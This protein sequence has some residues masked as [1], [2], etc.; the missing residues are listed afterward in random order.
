MNLKPSTA[1]STQRTHKARLVAVRGSG[2]PTVTRPS[3]TGNYVAS[4][5]KTNPGVLHQPQALKA[6]AVDKSQERRETGEGSPTGDTLTG[7]MVEVSEAARLSLPVSQDTETGAVM[8]PFVLGKGKRPLMPAHPARVRQLLRKRKA[9]VSRRFPFVIRLKTRKDGEVQPI[10]VKLDP[11]AK[12]TGIALVRLT[13]SNPQIQTVLGRIE[14]THR[15]TQIRDALTQ[16]RSFRGARCGRKTRYRAPRFLNRTKPQGW[17]PP[18]LRHRLE[19]TMSW[20][21]RLMLNTPE[22]SAIAGVDVNDTGMG[23]KDIRRAIDDFMAR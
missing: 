18:S 3:S 15:G 10:A 16:R 12:T 19:T 6:H 22:V 11:G 1:Q 20:V 7:N 8:R 13:P 5:S 14:L 23:G 21:T 2:Q 9:T 4:K 17:L